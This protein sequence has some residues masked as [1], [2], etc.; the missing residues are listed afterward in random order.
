MDNFYVLSG[1]LIEKCS[2]QVSYHFSTKSGAIDQLTLGD[3]KV[4]RDRL[5]GH[6][7]PKSTEDI[8]NNAKRRRHT[9]NLSKGY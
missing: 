4:D 1:I 6:P 8:P 7:Y 5:V 3:R 2:F 9:K